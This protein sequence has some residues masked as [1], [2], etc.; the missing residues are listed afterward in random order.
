MNCRSFFLFSPVLERLCPR[1]KKSYH[2]ASKIAPSCQSWHP[3]WPSWAQLGAKLAILAHLGAIMTHLGTIMTHLGAIM[4]PSCH[5]CSPSCR[6]HVRISFE[7]HNPR[8]DIVQDR[9]EDASDTSSEPHKIEKN[10]IKPN[11][12]LCCSLSR[13]SPKIL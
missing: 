11:L 3:S 8:A 9:P 4:S 5:S 12:F 6:Q 2:D 10:Q 7:K 13:R 1:C